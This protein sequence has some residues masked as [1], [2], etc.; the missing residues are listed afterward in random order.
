MGVR[1][2][3]EWWDGARAPWSSGRPVSGPTPQP[4]PPSISSQLLPASQRA[5]SIAMEASNNQQQKKEPS[6]HRP[7]AFDKVYK[8]FFFHPIHVDAN[9]LKIN[10]FFTFS[11][12]PRVR[13]PFYFFIIMR[14]IYS[15]IRR[16]QRSVSY[17]NHWISWWKVIN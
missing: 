15:K 16:I 3:L 8:F 2:W 10:R 13:G 4:P 1:G 6:V 5:A 17:D 11:S 9:D 12:I 7:C 14:F